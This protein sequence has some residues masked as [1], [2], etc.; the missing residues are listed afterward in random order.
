MSYL[1]LLNSCQALAYK[2]K[3]QR[4]KKN[5]KSFSRMWIVS[6]RSKTS[7]QEKRSKRLH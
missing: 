4:I 5:A 3:T 1:K 2:P 7:G 6:N